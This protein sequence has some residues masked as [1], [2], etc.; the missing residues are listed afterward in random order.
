MV[1]RERPARPGG[2]FLLA[3]LSISV[4][5][6][7]TSALTT[8]YLKGTPWNL[9]DP[10][11]DEG[12][13]DGPGGSTAERAADEAAP[14]TPSPEAQAAAREAAIEQA[15]TSLAA[16]GTV[17]AATEAVLIALLRGTPQ[18]D[19]P[20]VV[21]EFV[22]ALA[23]TPQ[24]ASKP[25][26]AADALPEATVAV[27]LADAQP[28]TVD[29]S[30]TAPEPPDLTAAVDPTVEA[31]LPVMAA[32][33]ADL[34]PSPRS[35]TDEAD[36]RSAPDAAG[37]TVS[38]AVDT[39]QAESQRDVTVQN[40]CFAARV[41]A[42]GVV[43]RFTADRFRPGQEVIVYFELEHLSAD[44]T[45]A[46]HTTCIDTSL[47]LVAADG[48]RIHDWSFE[49]IRETCPARRRDYFARYVVRIP[50]KSPAGACRLEIAVTDTLAGRT[51]AAT[52]PLEIV[53]D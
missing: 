20:A 52:L 17:D 21:D 9:S 34:V 30:P 2:L 53:A 28:A 50:A 43:D 44:R 41:Q 3:L 26:P 22:G 46:G 31:A 13:D 27:L 5:A 18:E 45:S 38:S 4:P 25:A 36:G 8:A 7:C 14:Q 48:G 51:A 16:V 37:S 19:W 32:G 29:L 12:E 40:A 1:S 42:W 11:G 39:P 47:V 35:E 24:V 33:N 15:I 10:A 6:G 49:P 23:A